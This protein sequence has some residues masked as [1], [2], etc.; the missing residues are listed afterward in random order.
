[1][2]NWYYYNTIGDK[3]EVTGK[4]LKELARTGQ[5][6]PGT[7]VETEDGK[8]APAKRV[9]GLIFGTLTSLDKLDQN[10]NV[11]ND[12][13]SIDLLEKTDIPSSSQMQSA[14]IPNEES[15]KDAIDVSTDPH[16]GRV[17]CP[18]CGT[19]LEYIKSPSNI[20]SV[21][22]QRESGAVLSATACCLTG[23]VFLIVFFPIT[24]ML[25]FIAMVI[26]LIHVI[27][28][29]TKKDYDWFQLLVCDECGYHFR[30]HWK[31][32]LLYESK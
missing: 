28:S 23:C 8:T 26:M 2:A 24:I 18:Q 17:I 9:K 13:V 29:D 31:G 16:I 32:A 11:L 6:T 20:D 15:N 10:D 12:A 19:T 21:V 4:E 22:Q 5:I 30:S 14:V 25:W 1:M 7:M 3:I 27:V